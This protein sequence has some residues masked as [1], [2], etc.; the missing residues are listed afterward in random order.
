MRDVFASKK[1]YMSIGAV[2]VFF[3]SIDGAVSRVF[4]SSM[5]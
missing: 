3:Y 5:R 4:I 1:R 2:D